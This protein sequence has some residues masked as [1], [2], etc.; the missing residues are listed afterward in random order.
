MA[1]SN[2][3]NVSN[4]QHGISEADIAQAFEDLA[5]GERTASALENQLSSVEKRVDD[6]LAQAEIDQKSLEQQEKA[7]SAEEKKFPKDAS[8]DAASSEKQ[9]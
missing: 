5:R 2:V 9:S 7:S 3:A 1:D 8:D 4:V 6:L